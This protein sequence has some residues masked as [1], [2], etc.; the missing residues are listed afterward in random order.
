MEIAA[1]FALR[2]RPVDPH[3]LHELRLSDRKIRRADEVDGKTNHIDL[4]VLDGLGC[5]CQLVI[6]TE[7]DSPELYS[8]LTAENNVISKTD[9]LI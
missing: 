4:E 7:G 8:I 6:R 2:S 3:N 9:S 5:T 1:V